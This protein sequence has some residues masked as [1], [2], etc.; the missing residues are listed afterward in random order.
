MT[1]PATPH[2]F[3]DQVVIVTGAASGIGLATATRFAQEGARVVIAD[4]H[5][6]QAQAAA[7]QLRAHGAADALGLPCDVSDEAQVQACVAQATQ[8]FGTLD[9]VVNNAGLMTFKAITDLTGDDWRRVLGVDLI[10][11]FFF[12]REAFRAMP[13]GGRIV[14]VSSIHAVETSPL[15]APYAA[16]KAAVVSLTR[17]AAIEGRQRGIRVNAVLPGAVNTPMLWDNPNVKSGVEKIDRSLVGEPEDLAAAIAFL[18]SPEARFV[19]GAALVVDGGRI[20]IL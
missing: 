2:R 7:E 16:A 8:H 19:Q 20:D 17:S 3:Q 12:I 15:V 13:S 18:A 14:N 4:L 5:G 10:G 11:T 9:V 6:D 1:T